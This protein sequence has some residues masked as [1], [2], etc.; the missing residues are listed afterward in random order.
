MKDYYREI[1]SGLLLTALFSGLAIWFFRH[2]PDA[3]LK[4]TIAII[5][6]VLGIF[7]FI[8]NIIAKKRN[9]EAGAP[10]EDEFTKLAKV[11]AGSQAFIYSMYLWFLIFIFRSSLPDPEEMLG[12]GIMGSALIYGICLWYYKSR[13]GFNE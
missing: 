1:I 12:V 7:V 13:G 4:I 6:I 9:L 11:Y 2:E 5:T 10:P 3:I 8:R